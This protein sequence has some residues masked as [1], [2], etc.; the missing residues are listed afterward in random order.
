MSTRVKVGGTWV[1]VAAVI[2]AI[3]AGGGGDPEAT[4]NIWVELGAG[5]CT[6]AS[7][8]PVTYEDA[9][10]PDLR[11]GSLDQAWDAMSSG[12]TARIVPGTYG[13]Q[14][15]TGDKSATTKFIGNGDS[16]DDVMFRD[17]NECILAFAA[18]SVL[19][20]RGA[21]FWLENATL[22]SLDTYGQSSAM[23]NWA[24]SDCGGCNAH[25]VTLKNVDIWGDYPN[26]FIEAQNFT[27]SGGS[28]RQDGT[29]MPPLDCQGGGQAMN[30]QSSAQFVVLEG[31]RVNP[32]NISDDPSCDP[33]VEAMRIQNTNN[34]TIRNN[35][36]VGGGEWGSGYIF[37]GAG[38]APEN[39][40]IY[41]NI[42]P[43]SGPPHLSCQCTTGANWF[44]GY[45]TFST[46][47]FALTPLTNVT[48]VGNYGAS[49]GCAATSIKN[50][51]SGSGSCGTDT[52]IGGA[53]LGLDSEGRTQAGSP[54]I[55]AAET[56]GASDHCTDAATI[57]SKDFE[58]QARPQ[59]SVCDAGAD[60]RV[61]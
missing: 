27:W 5:T 40:S 48:A 19:C 1:V 52:Y 41:N 31:L 9:A 59:G 50:V 11:C 42:F 13:P 12:Q 8:T 14:T 39:V 38:A 47:S 53:A 32:A 43:A 16:K 51:W 56:P 15:V 54:A 33:H 10:S 37:T 46:Q 30:M 24:N 17:T 18:N 35:R 20:L 22:D 34:V 28:W 58:G 44:V 57:A 7:S 21:H 29:V 49:I 23:R 45:N 36:F 60:E 4:A 3:L 2:A 25:H 26:L 61:P 6:T 55:D